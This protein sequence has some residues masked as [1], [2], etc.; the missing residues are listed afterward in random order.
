MKKILYTSFDTVPAP[1]GAGTHISY[2]TESLV[3]EG[4][5]VTLVVPLGKGQKERDD[6]LGAR[7]KRID[8]REDNF[9]KRT[10]LFRKGVME[11]LDRESY[12]IVHFRSIWEGLAVVRN[13]KKFKIIYEVN[14]F[15]SI[16]LPYHYS[17]LNHNKSVIEKMFIQETECLLKADMVI[18]PSFQIKSHIISRG[19]LDS[20]VRVIP[21]GVDSEIFF[22]LPFPLSL[23]PLKLFYMGTLTSW[24]GLYILLEGLKILKGNDV[25]FHMDILSNMKKKFL[26][27]L[28]DEINRFRLEKNITFIP[29]VPHKEVALIIG[30]SHIC[31]APLDSSKRNTVQGCCPLKILEYMACGRPV[32]ASDISCVREILTDGEDGL[33]YNPENFHELADK[34]LFLKERPEIMKVIAERGR[35]KVKKKYSWKRAG[36]SLWEIVKELAG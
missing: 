17:Q 35:E 5:D 25:S 30:N 8:V 19:I 23:T 16:E 27:P 12:D 34:I 18:C 4:Y 36:R 29:S 9:L 24:Q 7:V 11:E 6:Y 2:F 33:L 20:K 10:E 31:L 1:K 15:P 14:G 32:I 21:N 22:P 3:K 26:K 28:K 13:K